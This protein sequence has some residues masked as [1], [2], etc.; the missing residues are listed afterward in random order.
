MPD[1]RIFNFNASPAALPMDVLK[2][3]E[4]RFGLLLTGNETRLIRAGTIQNASHGTAWS[5]GLSK[6]I[7]TLRLSIQN[8]TRTFIVEINPLYNNIVNGPTS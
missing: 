1:K 3:K 5:T 4:P 6:E 2:E 7:I 8:T